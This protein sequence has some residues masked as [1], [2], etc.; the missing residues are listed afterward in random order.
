M[1]I[2]VDGHGHRG[3]RHGGRFV[4]IPVW[5][6]WEFNEPFFFDG[7]EYE[8]VL[9]PDGSIWLVEIEPDDTVIPIEQ[10]F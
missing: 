1:R 4:F 3:Y 2:I 6:G 7:I 5:G 8:K 10:E 9:M